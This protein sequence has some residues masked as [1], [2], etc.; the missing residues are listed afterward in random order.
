MGKKQFI[1]SGEHRNR[2]PTSCPSH[3]KSGEQ[4]T[5]N[6]HMFP[7]TE[8]VALLSK[9]HPLSVGGQTLGESESKIMNRKPGVS[10]RLTT[11]SLAVFPSVTP[12]HTCTRMSAHEHTSLHLRLHILG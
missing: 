6:P 7:A 5:G 3:S 2:S 1:Q 9:F 10:H 8:S 12:R 11:V 4:R